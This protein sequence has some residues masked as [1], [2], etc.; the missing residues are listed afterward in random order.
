MKV[1]PSWL[2]CLQWYNTIA[3][4]SDHG[5]GYM[6]FCALSSNTLAF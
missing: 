2:D 4:A 5:M 1:S 3:E 6:A